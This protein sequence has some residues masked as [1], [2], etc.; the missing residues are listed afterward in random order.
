MPLVPTDFDVV[1][2]AGFLDLFDSK[3]MA[4]ESN[5][6]SHTELV[7]AC[8]AGYGLMFLCMMHPVPNQAYFKTLLDRPRFLKA[9]A[10]AIIAQNLHTASNAC[11]LALYLFSN[12]GVLDTLEFW[13]SW[14]PPIARVLHR[15]TLPMLLDD[16]RK[17]PV[18]SLLF[19][20]RSSS[21][22]SNDLNEAE[23][24][25][26]LRKGLVDSILKGICTRLL[27]YPH[28]FALFRP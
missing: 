15:A 18:L 7:G 14:A 22:S 12:T 8:F 19:K 4:L 9:L 17:S 23:E 6:G 26:M 3:L 1:R 20:S 25:D 5:P 10:N 16:L 11:T 24:I 28:H 27:N 21:S 13:Q 2:N